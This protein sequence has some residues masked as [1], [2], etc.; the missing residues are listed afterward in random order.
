MQIGVDIAQ[1]FGECLCFGLAQIGNSI[2]L[3]I[4]VT[5][6]HGVKIHQMQMPNTSTRQGKGNVRAKSAQSSNAYSCPL[7]LFKHAWAVSGSHHAFQQFTGR[8]FAF[9][10]H[11]HAVAVGKRQVIIGLKAVDN[12]N[13][14]IAVRNEGK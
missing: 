11:G 5:W 13:A 8:Q 1:L 3:P 9:G 4:E 7:D 14:V 12:Q 2:T 10:N 6:L